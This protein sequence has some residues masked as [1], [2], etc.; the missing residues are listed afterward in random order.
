MKLIVLINYIYDFSKRGLHQKFPFAIFELSFLTTSSISFIKMTL[1]NT[2]LVDEYSPMKL[3]L[4][5]LLPYPNSPE[6]PKKTI[7]I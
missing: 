5:P 2:A 4:L 7:Y 1:E 6:V 3:L